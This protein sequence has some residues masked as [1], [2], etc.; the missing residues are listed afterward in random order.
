MGV[1]GASTQTRCTV[2]VNCCGWPICWS[3]TQ[4][5]GTLKPQLLATIQAVCRDARSPLSLQRSSTVVRPFT[6]INTLHK[7]MYTFCSNQNDQQ[8]VNCCNI[9]SIFPH[10]PHPHYSTPWDPLHV[11]EHVS[12]HNTKQM[13][14]W[15]CE[16]DYGVISQMYHCSHAT[17]PPRQMFEGVKGQA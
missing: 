3:S 9:Y 5:L 2:T 4:S 11:F 6:Y 15:F 8:A 17:P 12:H 16:L 7:P 10:S 13:L 14:I 1:L